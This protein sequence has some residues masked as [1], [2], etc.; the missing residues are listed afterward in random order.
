M[1]NQYNCIIID[2]E[3]D[4]VDLL[5]S[6][7]H[8]LY[9]NTFIVD[10]FNDWKLALPALRSKKYDL[11]FL[12]VSMPGKTGIELLQLLPDLESEII[13]VTAHDSYALK[14]FSFAAS[15]YVLKPIDDG[16]LSAAI[17]RALA[18]IKIKNLAANTKTLQQKPSE[19]IGIANN[20]GVDYVNI[21]DIVYLESMNKC[22]EIVT[23]N[24]KFT[25]TSNIGTFKHLLD[26]HP[27][28]QAH[29]SFII[30][31]NRIHRYETSGLIIMQDKKEIP[32]SRALRNDFLKLFENQ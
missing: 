31:L 2:D 8:L 17:E 25:S 21:S 28:F 1:G 20:H 32:L 27:F 24:A 14:A 26:S 19:K 13:F 4:A 9:E 11:L 15:G 18:R 7:L 5:K 3:Q 10:S 30:N 29:R 12:D 22:T 6:R 16:E 23:T